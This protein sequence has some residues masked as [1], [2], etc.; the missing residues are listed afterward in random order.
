MVNNTR[1][2]IL[3]LFFLPLLLSSCRNLPS[4][5]NNDSTVVNNPQAEV[6]ETSLSEV[7]GED[8]AKEVKELEA[9]NQRLKSR[10]IF[11]R[12]FNIS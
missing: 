10:N 5:S 12:I 7:N 6:S 9:E 3:F 4:K 8:M 1:S 2:I 11:Q